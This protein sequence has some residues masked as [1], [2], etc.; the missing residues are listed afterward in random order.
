MESKKEETSKATS[1]PRGKYKK[2]DPKVIY[3]CI[4]LDQEEIDRK[5]D[6]IY[7]DLFDTTW[8]SR[9]WYRFGSTR[10]M[11]YYY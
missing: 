11:E 6:K 4:E 10:Y 1:K 8:E 2:A 3:Q 5:L 9:N 7:D